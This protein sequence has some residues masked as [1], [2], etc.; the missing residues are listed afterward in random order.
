MSKILYQHVRQENKATSLLHPIVREIHSVQNNPVLFER[1]AM[2]FIHQTDLSPIPDK[3]KGIPEFLE[4]VRETA[5]AWNLTLTARAHPHCIF[6][7]AELDENRD[8]TFLCSL[9]DYADQITLSETPVPTVCIRYYTHG[10]CR[11]GE[12]L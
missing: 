10:F 4:I 5:E 8:L 1:M 7:E 2:D 3:I 12:F 9:A 11:N 6:I